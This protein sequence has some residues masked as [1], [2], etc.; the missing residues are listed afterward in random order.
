MSRATAAVMPA[1]RSGTTPSGVYYE[2]HG[3][4]TP[5]FL[6]F[7]LMA[8]HGEVF[9][10][11]AG[12]ARDRFLADLLDRYCV[13]LADYPSIGRS[14]TIPPAQLTLDRVCADM[15][16][17]ADDAGVERFAWWGA[18]FGAVTGMA[19]AARSDRVTAL[20]SAGWSPL[21][22]PYPAMVEAALAQ[23]HDPPMHARVML[24]DLAQYAQWGT[25][26][27]SLGAG[28]EE[29]TVARIRCP[30][31]V[32]YGEHAVSSVGDCPLPIAATVRARRTDLVRLGWE[33]I[34]IPGADAS[35]V[36]QPEPLVPAARRY[37]DS[38]LSDS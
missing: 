4:G 9:G 22:M 26:Y 1:L 7:P 15:L 6:G 23:L 31:A 30:R 13:L 37:F 25:F 19:L 10:A 35:L 14:A 16:A 34:E 36:L 18:T 12:A 20:L 38:V 8:S 2:V 28:W 11:E 17:V 3:S 29:G 24:R 5:L 33:V 21:G 32:I 27:S